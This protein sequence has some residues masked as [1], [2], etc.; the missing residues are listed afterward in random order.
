M[1]RKDD[2]NHACKRLTDADHRLG[3]LTSQMKQARERAIE[4][5]SKAR[6][7]ARTLPVDSDITEHA[8]AAAARARDAATTEGERVYWAELYAK[9]AAGVGAARDAVAAAERDLVRIEDDFWRDRFAESCA[10]FFHRNRAD[11]RDMFG[12]FARMRRDSYPDLGDFFD[13]VLE[14]G[15]QDPGE[16]RPGIEATAKA[17][18]PPVRVPLAALAATPTP[19]QLRRTIEES[20]QSLASCSRGIEELER[21]IDSLKGAQSDEARAKTE[22]LKKRLD[23]LLGAREEWRKR[24]DEL[25][26]QHA[27]ALLEVEALRLSKS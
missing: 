6:N 18:V 26:A 14:H 7:A 23:G 5:V 19:E 1:S 4:C 16:L 2:F 22:R 17:L 13:A 20:E 8:A 25:T 11:L 3:V 15:P 24:T 12:A 10:A 21:E 27:L 9:T